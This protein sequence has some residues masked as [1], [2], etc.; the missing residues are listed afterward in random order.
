MPEHFTPAIK[1]EHDEGICFY[2]LDGDLSRE[3][4]IMNCITD[5]VYRWYY[6]KK[7]KE[8]NTALQRVKDLEKRKTDG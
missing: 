3:Y 2:L 6:L 7:V 5:K 8:L 1:M 4:E